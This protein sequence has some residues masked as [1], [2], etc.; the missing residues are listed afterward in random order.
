M[1][2]VKYFINER[3]PQ[4]VGFA[5]RM[6]EA[7][8]DFSSLPTFGPLTLSIGGDTAYGLTEVQQAVH[9]LIGEQQDSLRH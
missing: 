4:A 9:V 1:C 8:I 5:E 7:G 2:R 3:E 6:T